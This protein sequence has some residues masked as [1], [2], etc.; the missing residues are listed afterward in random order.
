M[1]ISRGSDKISGK[2]KNQPASIATFLHTIFTSLGFDGIFLWSL[3]VSLF[4]FCFR[5]IFNALLMLWELI[6]Q[7][8]L[9]RKMRDSENWLFFWR[10]ASLNSWIR[11]YYSRDFFYYE[12]L[13]YD[14]ES[15]SSCL[16]LFF[17][18]RANVTLS[19]SWGSYKTLAFYELIFYFYNL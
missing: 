15:I 10:V 7:Q 13:F 14:R 9:I 8:E 6:K 17:Y 4:I 12:K 19:L 16:S 2:D 3:Y 18:T 11:D 1:R 5:L